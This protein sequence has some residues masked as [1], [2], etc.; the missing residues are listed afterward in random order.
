VKL[1]D[2]I[3]NPGAQIKNIIFDWGGVIT[4]L[5]FN[6]SIEAFKKYG[7]DNFLDQYNMKFQKEFY[8][9]LE[10]GLISPEEFRTELRKLIPNPITDI[11][12]D[13]AWAALLC[14]LP[15]ERWNLLKKLKKYF[16][17]FLLSNTNKIHVERYFQKIYE[18]YGEYGY[19]NLFEKTYFS[20]ELNMRKPDIKIFEFVLNDNNLKP[21]ETLMI[22]DFYENIESAGKLGIVTYQIKEPVTLMDLFI[23]D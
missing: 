2:Q 18:K 16:R 21:E 12:L 3:L 10:L 8:T 1:F 15:R 5:D 14:E 4:D 13:H 17:T 23:N 22:D 19:R 6:A 7:M 11:E 9:R 20:Y